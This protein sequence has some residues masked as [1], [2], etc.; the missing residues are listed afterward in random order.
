MNKTNKILLAVV[1]LLAIG[2]GVWQFV[3]SSGMPSPR[4]DVSN[5]SS[6]A[7][8]PSLTTVTPTAVVA[9]VPPQGTTSTPVEKGSCWTNS[10]SAPYRADA[11]RCTVGN[12]ISDPCFQ[13]PNSKN[14]LCGVNP[15]VPDATSTFM[16]QLTSALP[17][18]EVLP[19]TPP[20]DWAWLV[21]LSD[22]TLCSPF[23]G[24]RPFT[25]TGQAAD[26]GCAPGSLGTDVYIF[27]DF[28]TSNSVWLANVGTLSV[29]TSSLPTIENSKE[30]PIKTVWQ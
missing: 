4:I 18:P 15:A 2:L 30:V 1:V 13:I 27:D 25:A 28:N 14:L 9:Y 3:T 17:K 23:T 29:P 20:T 21:Q 6:T 24:T 7:Q 19:G 8:N 5:T 26:Y 22:G 12:A 11:W 16:L 10:I